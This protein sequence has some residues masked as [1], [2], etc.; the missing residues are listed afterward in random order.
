MNRSPILYSRLLRCFSLKHVAAELDFKDSGELKIVINR[1]DK[2]KKLRIL[3]QP[4][5]S[6]KREEWE[7]VEN[8]I[9]GSLFQICADALGKGQSYNKN[10]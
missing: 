8:P 9:E 10:E 4:G 5:G 1:N 3:C 2:L 7:K 6:I